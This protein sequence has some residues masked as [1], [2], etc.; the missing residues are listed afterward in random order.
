[1]ACIKNSRSL[2]C[3]HGLVPA[4]LRPISLKLAFEPEPFSPN[5]LTQRR[6]DAKTLRFYLTQKR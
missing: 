2:K 6:K 5:Y 4:S 1:M 3:V